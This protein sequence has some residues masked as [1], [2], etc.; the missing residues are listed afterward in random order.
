MR[1]A[2][3]LVELMVV[4]AVIALLIALL[5]PSLN[6]ARYAA[7]LTV[8]ASN[9]RQIALGSTVYATEYRSYY[10]EDDVPGMRKQVA[11]AYPPPLV[12]YVGS[13]L[14]GR[15]NKTWQCPQVGAEIDILAGIN[16]R[17]YSLYYTS[18]SSLKSGGTSVSGSHA[19][20]TV[21]AEAMRKIGEPRVTQGGSFFGGGNWETT[22]LAS[23]IAHTW[24]A[25]VQTGHM[26]QG[27]VRTNGGFGALRQWTTGTAIANYTY[28]DGHVERFSFARTNI[29]L[30]MMVASSSVAG[31]WDQYL[32]PR[33]SVRQVP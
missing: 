19:T 10:P 12:G 29:Q 14:S 3:T 25:F 7:R 16:D 6:S 18:A 33:K 21:P 1:K 27:G 17:T 13:S 5:L 2:F 28:Q 20:P 30:T 9:L 4:I 8:C 32:L 23:D 22:I 15:Y 31:S 26:P 11:A 24:S